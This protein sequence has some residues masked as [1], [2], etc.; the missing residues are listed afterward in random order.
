[1]KTDEIMKRIENG[2]SLADKVARY[3]NFRF[4]YMFEKASIEEDKKLMIDYKCSKTKKTAQ[5]KCRENKSDIIYEAKRFYSTSGCFYEEAN[6]RDV[7]T[8]AGL[9]IC[10]SADKRK[11]IVAETEAV[12]KIVQKEIQ[13]LDITLDQVKQY[14]QECASNKN[15]TKKLMSNKSKIEVWFKIDEGVDSRHYSKLL[16]F[17]PYSAIFESVIIDLREH[18][19]I[20]DERTWKNG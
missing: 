20:E 16:V 3:L 19:N 6:G 11:I 15:K 17:I 2:N 9:Y 12:K 14:E 10:L 18:E 8:E 13:K 7:R 4:K 5:M 1:M